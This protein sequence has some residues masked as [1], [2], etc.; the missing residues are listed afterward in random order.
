MIK[1]NPTR[2][3]RSLTSMAIGVL[4]ISVLCLALLVACDSKQQGATE[5]QEAQTAVSQSNQAASRD[6]ETIA[7]EYLAALLEAQ[8][9]MGSYLSIPGAHHNRLS[10]NSMTA[11]EDWQNKEDAWLQELDGIGEPDAIGS[12]DWITYGVL[13]ES[14]AGS[15]ATRICRSELWAA[16]SATAW[17]TGL[18][19]VFEIQPVATQE[20]RQQAYQRLSALPLYIDNEINKLRLGLELG[21]KTPRLTVEPTVNEVK[22]L[23]E[24]NSPLLSPAVRADDPAYTAK[25][26]KLFDQQL[27]PAIERFAQFLETEYIPQTREEIG[28]GLNP[29]GAACYPALVRSFATIE[30]VSV[31][32]HAMGLQQMAAIRAEMQIIIDQYFPGETIEG[33]LRNLNTNPDYTFGT[34]QDV[35]DYVEA[36]LVRAKQ[37]MPVAF[38]QLPKAD[39]IIKPYPPYR[40]S[41][42]GEYQSSSEDGTRPGIFYIAVKNPQQRSKAGQQSVLFHETYPG[43]HLQGAIALELGDS[44]HPIVR[45]L[46]NSGYAEGWGLYSERLADELGLYSG[47]ID[48][49]GMLS[50]QAGRAARLVIDSGIHTMGWTVQ[51]AHG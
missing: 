1:V 9:E 6:I 15:V 30:P 35:V 32:I 22:A 33:L 31:E 45:Y 21:Y 23:Q 43:H 27:V 10:D 41:G 2:S 18:P 26:R 3:I 16:S 48:R 51:F 50:D 36:G 7:D 49:M 34:E 17:Y 5:K 14:L 29:D 42:T 19:S 24:G 38:G 25:I 12:R 37:K 28:V 44:V 11:L 40:D 47:P 46:W 13:H 8:P 4:C 20:Q 39:V